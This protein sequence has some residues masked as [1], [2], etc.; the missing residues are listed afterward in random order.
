LDANPKLYAFS[1]RDSDLF[2]VFVAND[3]NGDGVLELAEF[4]ALLVKLIPA[5][6]DLD[7]RQICALYNEVV[8]MSLFSYS[9]LSRPFSISRLSY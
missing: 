6:A 7:D 2:Q 9:R 4:R 8:I 1:A 5:D 3:T